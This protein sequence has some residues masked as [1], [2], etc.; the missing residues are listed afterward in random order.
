[1]NDKTAERKRAIIKARLER[2]TEDYESISDERGKDLFT[3][4][5]IKEL[6]LNINRKIDDGEKLYNRI[7]PFYLGFPFVFSVV[8]F[9]AALVMY[10]FYGVK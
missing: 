9:I 3:S 6:I 8:A 5:Q 7:A 2:Q 4:E 1:M 10:L